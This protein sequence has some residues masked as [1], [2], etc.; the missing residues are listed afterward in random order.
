MNTKV[1]KWILKNGKKSMIFILLLTI[2]SVMLSLIALRF[3]IESKNI[4]DIAG[5]TKPFIYV[6][7]NICCQ[8]GGFL[9]LF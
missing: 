8:R 5:N 7:A 4:I 3:S 6:S 2:A 9:Y 1:L